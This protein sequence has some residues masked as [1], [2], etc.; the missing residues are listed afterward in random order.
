MVETVSQRPKPTNEND[1]F[2]RN[3]PL[4]IISLVCVDVM[5][6]GP[7]GGPCGVFEGLCGAPRFRSQGWSHQLTWLNVDPSVGLCS[8]N[9]SFPS[10]SF[11]FIPQTSAIFKFQ[12]ITLKSFSK[13]MIGCVVD[14]LASGKIEVRVGKRVKVASVS[15]G[16]TRFASEPF[17]HPQ[18]GV[19]P[20]G[21]PVGAT[22]Q[23][24]AIARS[25]CLLFKTL[26]A[27]AV[28]PVVARRLNTRRGN[29]TT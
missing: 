16:Q 10:I 5:F 26:A 15:Y 9:N 22:I 3:S 28:R 23:C 29:H 18:G 24:E 1:V 20:F 27:V 6:E 11:F 4:A 7:R 12:L 14:A 2:R 17:E 13:T 8:K 25:G 19:G 21:Y